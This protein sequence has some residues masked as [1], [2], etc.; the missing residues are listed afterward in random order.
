[1]KDRITID[2]EVYV[3]EASLP[4]IPQPMAGG[5]DIK[6]MADVLAY[7]KSHSIIYN[8]SDLYIGTKDE[9]AYKQLKLMV[10]A[11]SEKRKPDYTNSSQGKYYPYFEVKADKDRPSGFGFSRTHSAYWY[12]CTSVGSRL[13]FPSSE[14]A[15]HAAEFFKQ[16]YIDFLLI[17]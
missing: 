8:E 1:M 13:C 4:V 5:L 16:L 11:V 9:Q 7:C 12:S 17:S 3:R 2:S 10:I 15:L 14:L 6:T